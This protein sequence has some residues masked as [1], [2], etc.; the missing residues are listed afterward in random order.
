MFHRHQACPNPIP[1]C[2]KG[3]DF[4]RDDTYKRDFGFF[5]KDG[6]ELTIAER[7]F[8]IANSFPLSNC[9]NHTCWQEDWLSVEKNDKIF[10]DHCTLL[11]RAS[12]DGEALQQLESIKQ[13][14]PQSTFLINCKAKWGF[15]FALDGIDSKGDCFE[16]LHI[17]YDSRDYDLFCLQLDLT[18]RQI[19][20]IDWID[21]ANRIEQHKDKWQHL[22]GFE[23]N[24]WKAEFLLNWSRAETLEKA[25]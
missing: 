13:Y 15:D 12:F 9:L 16:V 22:K 6:Y 11:H 24:H 14:I 21:A 17:E 19:Y 18:E 25:I 5:D 3:V 2:I 8:Y 10:F 7:M 4:Y 20:N 23:Q 1:I